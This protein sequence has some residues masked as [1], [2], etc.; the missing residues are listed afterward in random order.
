MYGKLSSLDFSK[1]KSGD[2]EAGFM[3]CIWLKIVLL[4]LTGFELDVVLTLS[5]FLHFILAFCGSS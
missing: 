4:L 1:P 5:F 2:E 3:R